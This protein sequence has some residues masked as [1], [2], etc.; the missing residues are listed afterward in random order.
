MTVQ[1]ILTVTQIA[2]QSG[3]DLRICELLLN[4]DKTD[5]EEKN[6]CLGFLK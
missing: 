6:Q 4:E 1:T 5:G 2:W 3:A